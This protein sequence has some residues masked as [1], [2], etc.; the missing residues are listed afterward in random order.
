M[1]K[2]VKVCNY[3]ADLEHCLDVAQAHIRL[4]ALQMRRS[5]PVYVELNDLVAD[6]WVGL[7][8]AARAFDPKRN[9]TFRTYAE[10]RIRGAILDSLRKIDPLPRTLR[11]QH[12]QVEQAIRSLSGELRREPTEEEIA[13]RLN[14]CVS[15]WRTLRNRLYWAGLR[16]TGNGDNGP[17]VPIDCLPS[18]EPGPEAAA[19]SAE[20]LGLLTEALR[21]LPELD[22]YVLRL[23]Y[24]E[25]WTSQQIGAELGVHASR[26]SQLHTAAVERLRRRFA[27][28]LPELR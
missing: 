18:C 24:V 3:D 4:I 13:A 1:P 2:Q 6:G 25:E 17:P 15:D 22:R 27:T 5:F 9:V 28:F 11:N 7:L 19:L 16:I 12:R 21:T 8:M 14:L 26:A 10:H 20:L 23:R